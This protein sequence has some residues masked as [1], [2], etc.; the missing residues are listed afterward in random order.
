MQLI[1]TQAPA[2]LIL[3]WCA[4]PFLGKIEHEWSHANVPH[5]NAGEFLVTLRI[6]I[7]ELL[8]GVD[9]N[10]MC[11]VML[12]VQKKLSQSIK[13]GCWWWVEIKGD[14]VWENSR[15]NKRNNRRQHLGMAI[16]GL[17]N[18]INEDGHGG[19]EQRGDSQFRTP[20]KHEVWDQNMRRVLLH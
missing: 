20:S 19:E 9:N 13:P 4:C 18:A 14:S 12:G 16:N 2:Y 3:L 17:K 8:K 7:F 6:P 15:D 5:F 10:T 1:Y 11:V